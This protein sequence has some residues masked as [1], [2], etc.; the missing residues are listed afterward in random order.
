MQ[1]PKCHTDNPEAAKFCIECASPLEIKCPQCGAT[2]PAKAKF[3]MECAHSLQ[4]QAESTPAIQPESIVEAS[5]ADTDNRTE[6][7][8][9]VEGERKHVTVLFS[10]LSGYT[11]LSENLDP[12][13]VKEIVG[14]IFG[15]IKS[16]I[17]KYEGFIEKFAGDAVMAIFGVPRAHEDDPVRAI[18]AAR[19]IHDVVDDMSPGLVA[20]IGRPLSMH[21]GIN[22]GLVVTGEINPEKGTHGVSGDTLNV[23]SRLSDLAESG[24]ILVGQAT[25]RGCE[26]Y[27]TF[28]SLKPAMVKGKQEPVP[29][30]R[31]LSAK[32]EPI[33]T[34]RASGLTSQLIGRNAE[35]AQL[36]EA[37]GRLQEGKGSILSVVGD[38]GTGKSRLVE[39]FRSSLD[40]TQIQWLQGHA[41]GYSQSMP[42][43]P[44]IDLL[45]RTLQI[46]EGDPPDTV[47]H[48][49]ESGIELLAEDRKD[50]APY[51]GRLYALDYPELAQITPENWKS[52]LQHAVR[53][54]LSNLTRTRPTIVCLEDLQWSDPSTLELMRF[55]LSDINDPALFLCTYRLPFSISTSHQLSGLGK[56]YQEIQLKDLSASEAQV[57]VQSMLKTQNIPAALQ[58]FIQEKLEGNPFYME[59]VVNALIES[60][61][62]VRENGGWKLTRPISE[63]EVSSTIYGVIS[64]RLDRLENETK[65]VL[66]EASVIGRTFLYEILKRVS[67]LKDSIDRCL[68]GLER[69]D[70]I[71]ARSL[72]PD[73]E[74]FFKHAMTQE[75]VYNGLLKKER[76]DI[77][78]RIGLVMEQIFHERLPELYETLAYHFKQGHSVPKAIA[79][80]M[81][82]GEKSL[83]RY[84]VEEAHQFYQ[85]AFEIL[86]AKNEKSKEEEVILID[87]LNSWGYVYY[88]LGDFKE[89]TALFAANRYLAESLGD[90]DRLGMFYVW[91]GIADSMS[92]RAKDAYEYLIKAQNLGQKCGNQKIEGYACTWLSWVC[93]ELGLYDEGILHGERAHQIAK[94]FPADQYLF[95]KS[96][97]GLAF[98]YT[99]MGLPQKALECGK[100]LLEHGRKYSNSRSNVMG[101]YSMSMGYAMAGNFEACI[102]SS[103]QAVAVSKDPFYSKFPAIAMNLAY[104]MDGQ[105]DKAM[106]SQQELVEFCEKYEVGELLVYENIIRGAAMV[107]SGRMDQGLK[108]IEESRQ[109]SAKNQRK[110]P[111]AVSEYVLG[112]IYS[113]IATGPKPNLSIMAKNI[114]FLIK[115][116]PSA[117]KK[118]EEHYQKAIEL[119]EEI[120]AN[121]Y[122]GISHLGLGQFYQAKKKTDQAGQYI[123][124]AIEILEECQAEQYL[125]KAKQAL[126]SLSD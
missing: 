10:D 74:Y 31:L 32:E 75:V 57:M 79:Y 4:D 59:E 124:K 11:A 3:C 53:M 122:R 22:T 8:Q 117:S 41:Y 109:I 66:Q 116:V 65:R 118:A 83:E 71:R 14:R 20:K 115:N 13:E 45:N 37:F 90:D 58:K 106:E 119:S 67:E 93:A 61:S 40:L 121:G 73:L 91:L 87:L 82:S 56:S 113:Q 17:D 21:T 108:I 111:L 89:F 43:F 2:N 68:S 18:K 98:V 24:E 42:Y 7:H 39:E 70:L 97:A 35:L 15:Q 94:N 54:V 88:Y 16:V 120:G 6:A 125:K 100:I 23:A 52:N 69:L 1:C 50:I 126:A 48:K 72:H 112:M 46:E 28:E 123:G 49:I 104:A 110:T 80:L 51:I 47:R 76:R 27:F 85:Q 103:R 44:L 38:A 33:T 81:K 36:Q 101:H 105:F 92:G 86:A 26:G 102:K 63:L 114:G 96:L 77:H 64:G 55:L 107:A 60:A 95:F 99:F 12:E 62:L 19:E 5:G 78:E 30:Y 29:I 25:Y 9:F 84:S 34:R